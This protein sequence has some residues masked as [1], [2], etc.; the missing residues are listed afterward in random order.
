MKT[1]IIFILLILLSINAQAQY[2][3][4]PKYL[5]RQKPEYH[6]IG[7]LKVVNKELYPILD[8][9][10]KTKSKVSYFN[11]GSLF[12]MWFGLDSIK[13][14][15]INIYAEGYCIVGQNHDLGLFEYK[16]QTFFVRGFSLDTTIFSKTKQKRLIDFSG[17][18]LD[19]YLKDGTPVFDP[20]ELHELWC[21][22]TCRY[23]KKQFKL[24]SFCSSDESIPCID[25]VEED[26]R[27]NPQ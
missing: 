16:N 12:T 25:H 24:L 8:S 10:I 23:K 5:Y 7:I 14:D 27:N 22:W 6:S 2:K 11:Q 13:H 19:K 18:L 17:R 20:M 9:I 3:Q 1:R 26:Y 15:L 4:N 21:T